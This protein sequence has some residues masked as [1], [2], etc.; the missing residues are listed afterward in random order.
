MLLK[1][2]GISLIQ[3]I[4]AFPSGSSVGAIGR[5]DVPIYLVESYWP[6][7]TSDLLIKAFDRTRHLIADMARRGTRIRDVTC[8]LIP[9]E[10]V[11]FSVYE[12]PSATAVRELSERAGIPVSRIVDAIAITGVGPTALPGYQRASGLIPGKALPQSEL[13][14]LARG[15]HQAAP[16]AADDHHACLGGKV[17]RSPPR[18][19]KA[20][21][22]VGRRR[23][24][25]GQRGRARTP[26]PREASAGVTRR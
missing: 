9:A 3:G 7:V 4:P 20:P 19:P 25:S 2:T 22:T 24:R 13:L 11:V 16:V 10:E 21:V 12:G 26:R 14:D 6:G 5:T 15:R 1:R 8:I 17:S 18:Q 23:G